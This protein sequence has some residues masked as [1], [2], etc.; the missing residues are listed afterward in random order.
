MQR[1]FLAAAVAGFI[2]PFVGN[3]IVP[4]KLSLLG[5][6][7]SHF[8]L[9]SLALGALFGVSGMYVAYVAVVVGVFAALRLVRGLGLSGDQVLAILL[10]LSAAVASVA[11]SRGARI[12]LTSVL[13]GSILAVETRDILAG[14]IVSISALVFVFHN[15]GGV[16]LYTVSEELA[17][18]R[19]VNVGLYEFLFAV[20]TGLAVAVSVGV[21]GVLLV[22]ALLVI[23]VMASGWIVS[24][25]RRAL[26]LSVIMGEVSLFCGVLL[27]YVF[28]I[29]PGAATV[30]V[31]LGVM[32][33]SLLL[34]RLGLRV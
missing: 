31:L 1:A 22:T 24:S 13:F 7:S 34:S 5:D 20:V 26:L 9:A 25:M 16:L 28:D 4:K 15:F 2:L 21:V 32:N 17:R 27:S 23:P 18:I 10:S 14:L 12:S 6:S 33:A 3:F 11:I 30:F 19:G 29:S 8:V